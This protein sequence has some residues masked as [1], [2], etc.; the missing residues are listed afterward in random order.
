MTEENLLV[1]VTCT[2][3]VYFNR[4]AGRDSGTCMNGMSDH[5]GHHLM[6]WHPVPSETVIEIDEVTKEE[7]LA[8]TIEC[9]SSGEEE[10]EPDTEVYN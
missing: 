1:P 3:C 5:Y 4:H 10:D 6:S 8:C 7:L 9:F 2:D